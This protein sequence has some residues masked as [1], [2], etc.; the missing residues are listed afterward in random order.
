MLVLNE[1]LDV[2]A[3]RR[4]R[5]GCLDKFQLDFPIVNPA[6]TIHLVEEGCRH[7]LD[8]LSD[9]SQIASRRDDSSDGD[10]ALGYAGVNVF[11]EQLQISDQ[12]CHVLP[13]HLVARHDV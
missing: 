11:A 12:V 9:A 13:R 5:I 2:R 3:G 7:G 1:T 4:G 10:A 6:L 8:G